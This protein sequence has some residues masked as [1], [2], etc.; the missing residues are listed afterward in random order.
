MRILLVEDEP[1]LAEQVRS[2]LAR[3]QY[4]VDVA[5]DGDDADF[6]GSTETYDAAILD[7]GLPKV[8]GL[9]VLRRW[10]AAGA[11]FPV[12]VLTARSDWTEKVDAID[13]GADDYVVKPAHLEELL[14]RIR[15]LLR[16]SA[17]FS[18]SV[19]RCGPLSVDTRRRSVS[20]GEGPVEVTANEY[21]LL[22]YLVHRC[23]AVVSRTELFEHLYPHDAER[24]SNTVEVF[25]ARLRKKIGARRITTIRGS[26][27]R[28][29]P[30]P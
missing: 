17:G 16:R 18:S 1:R 14:A 13:A 30:G 24:D 15:A 19:L 7:L 11:S 29:E 8:D 28:L 5:G 23:G 22:A 6:L 20:V 12:L 27:Y 25:V 2:A 3:D 9:T 26:G 4:A 10:R 21:Q